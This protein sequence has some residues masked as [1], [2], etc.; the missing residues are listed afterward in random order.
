[1]LRA[2]DPVIHRQER[3]VLVAGGGRIPRLPGPL[4]EAG[5][6]VK[7][8]WV[9]RAEDPLAWGQQRGVL[10]AG[11]GCPSMR[12]QRSGLQSRCLITFLQVRAFG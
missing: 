8:G 9:F 10:V 5:A 4:G 11:P 3:G 2:E 1:V 12:T 7:G 6:G